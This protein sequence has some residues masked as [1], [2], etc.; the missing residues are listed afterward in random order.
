MH[1]KRD[2]VARALNSVLAQTIGT[3]ELIVVDDASTDGSTDVLAT[4]DDPRIVK[5]RRDVPGPGGYAARNLGIERARGEW[6]AFL[7]AD[8]EWLPTHLANMAGLIEQNPEINIVSEGW[9]DVWPNGRETR[10]E[11]LRSMTDGAPKRLD[12]NEFVRAVNLGRT[13]LHTNVAT[14]RKSALQAAGGFPAGKCTRGGDTS[15]WL[16][17]MAQNRAMVC[18]SSVGAIYHREAS[19][20]TRG[21][22][23]ALA[24]IYSM[25]VA[26]D[27]LATERDSETGALLRKYINR[28][29]SRAAKRL[30]RNGMLTPADCRYFLLPDA[31][32]YFLAY[33]L[34]ALAPA[35]MQIQM[36]KAAQGF[37]LR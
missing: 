12:F 8:D 37:G 9:L 14:V 30:A 2:F 5:L 28:Q 29:A 17:L 21:K 11:F 4:F 3:F 18:A 10:G 6:I 23:R 31:I 36:M 19:T 25:R 27:L 16:T 22:P 32:G 33:S 26:K 1:N 35:S 34:C 15:L 24:D 20:V 7:D 13:P